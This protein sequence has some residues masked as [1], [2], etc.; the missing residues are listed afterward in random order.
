MKIAAHEYVHVWQYHNRCINLG[1]WLT[2]G[3]AEYVAFE[4]LIRNGVR[5]RPDVRDEMLQTALRKGQLDVPLRD[6]APRG[7]TIWPG[8][9]GY[10]AFDQLLSNSPED[11]LMPFRTLCDANGGGSVAFAG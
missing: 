10:L 1:M 7:N 11:G 5:N 6:L 3:M 2:E 8:P 9:A 4:T